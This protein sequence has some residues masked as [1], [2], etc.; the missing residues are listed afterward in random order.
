MP[1]SEID[2]FSLRCMYA[3]FSPLRCNFVS[4]RMEKFKKFMKCKGSHVSLKMTPIPSFNKSFKEKQLYK[5][6]TSLI[7]LITGRKWLPF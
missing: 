6:I 1:V 7:S 4:I 3:G 2:W 5:L